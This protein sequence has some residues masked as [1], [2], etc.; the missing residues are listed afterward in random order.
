[1]IPS[2]LVFVVVAVAGVDENLYVAGAVDEQSHGP[3][4]V[5]AEPHPD[6]VDVAAV[7]HP[8]PVAVDAVEAFLCVW[9]AVVH[10]SAW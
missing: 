1:M 10:W 3:V 6:L 9:P 8:E 4:G 5:A 2:I 7:Q